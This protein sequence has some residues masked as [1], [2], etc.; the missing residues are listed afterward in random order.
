[1]AEQSG[2]EDF[3]LGLETQSRRDARETETIQKESDALRYPAAHQELQELLLCALVQVGLLDGHQ[4]PR[5]D[6][7]AHAHLA[8]VVEAPPCGPEWK[9]QDLRRDTILFSG[10]LH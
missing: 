1:M 7:A 6:V 10:M 2:E 8:Q 4:L 3:I 5:S 9:G